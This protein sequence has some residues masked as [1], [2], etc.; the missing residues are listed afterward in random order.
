MSLFRQVARRGDGGGIKPFLAFRQFGQPEV[1]H[2]DAAV[3]GD[4]HVGRLQI[5]VR[6]SARMRRR[7]R[8]GDL[9]RDLEQT[10]D[11]HA[12]AANQVDKAL[13]FDE[14]HGQQRARR[15]LPRRRK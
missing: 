2:L 6:D 4:D 14:F 12:A 5:A 10:L 15:H 13:P 9:G 11:G 7:Q 8:V 3:G 1:E